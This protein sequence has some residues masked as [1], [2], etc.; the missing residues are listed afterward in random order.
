MLP[1]G[2]IGFSY[3]VTILPSTVSEHTEMFE[4]NMSHVNGS[5]I[6]TGSD[7]TIQIYDTSCKTC[8]IV[9][10]VY[11]YNAMFLSYRIILKLL[12]S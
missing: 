11:G 1:A 3:N 7:A 9:K 12:M 2:S 8:N 6:V 5:P 4:A 10:I